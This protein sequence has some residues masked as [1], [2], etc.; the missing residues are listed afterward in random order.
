MSGINLGPGTNVVSMLDRMMQVEGD[1]GSPEAGEI[2]LPDGR[3]FSVQ[4]GEPRDLGPLFELIRASASHE[5]AER[6]IRNMGVHAGKPLSRELISHLQRETVSA[7]EQRNLEAVAR[8]LGDDPGQVMLDELGRFD[9]LLRAELEGY[10]REIDVFTTVFRA[11]LEEEARRCARRG[12][13]MREEQVRAAIERARRDER[14]RRAPLNSRQHLARA[15]QSWGQ[16]KGREPLRE[17]VQK[18]EVEVRDGGPAFQRVSDIVR[19]YLDSRPL[20]P[21]WTSD[22]IARHMLDELEEEHGRK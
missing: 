14:L 8:L 5:V 15:V 19:Q 4:Q 13:E 11:L 20:A 18:I 7:I 16:Q 1:S 17:T 10:G 2:V 12:E 3:R 6:I 22:A 9:P 21:P